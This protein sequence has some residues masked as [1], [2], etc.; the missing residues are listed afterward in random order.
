MSFVE[1]SRV[2]IITFMMITVIF[3][4]LSLLYIHETFAGVPEYLKYKSKSFDGERQAIQM[5]GLD[6]AWRA[7][8]TSCFDCEIS[9]INQAGGNIKGGFLAK[10]MKY[11]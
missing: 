10:S 1:S 6:G 5:Y 2:S 3:C 9:A 8:P 4:I 7:N 11:Y